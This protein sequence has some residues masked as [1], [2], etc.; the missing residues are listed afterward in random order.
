ME[1]LITSELIQGGA[2]G[3]A[4]LLIVAVVWIIRIFVKTI[5]ETMLKMN[6]E[7]GKAN[8]N[9]L[10]ATGVLGQVASA[11][12]RNSNVIDQN[13]RLLER[14]NYKLDQNGYRKHDK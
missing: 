1:Q 5:N 11:L 10:N 14:F 12:N 8:A 4:I 2:V 13:T 7:I 9:H 6:E 3:L